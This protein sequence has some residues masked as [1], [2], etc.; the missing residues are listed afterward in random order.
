MGRLGI[1][2]LLPKKQLKL[3]KRTGVVGRNWSHLGLSRGLSKDRR[4]C[5]QCIHYGSHLRLGTRILANLRHGWSSIGKLLG[6]LGL[7]EVLLVLRH[8][9][10]HELLNTTERTR[11]GG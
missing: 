2:S 9:L 6:R 1:L 11:S 4:Y 8:M 5:L 7:L 3:L 10:P